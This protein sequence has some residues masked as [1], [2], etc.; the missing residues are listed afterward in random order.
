ML[1]HRIGEYYLPELFSMPNI[2][3]GPLQYH[4]EGDLFTHSMQVMQ[5][6]A[7]KS[8]DPLARFCGFFHDLGKLSTDPT[9]YPKHHGHDNGRAGYCSRDILADADSPSS[10]SDSSQTDSTIERGYGS[11]EFVVLLC[12]SHAAH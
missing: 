2:P 10:Q 9:L 11:A 4:P 5:R 12:L 1:H 8:P 7:A 3:A 6:V